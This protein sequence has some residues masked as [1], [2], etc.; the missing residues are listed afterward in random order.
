VDIDEFNDGLT[1]EKKSRSTKASVL[2]LNP[3]TRGILHA[4]AR[5]STGDFHPI[6]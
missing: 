3:H 6:E 2:R 4:S 1:N 5:I